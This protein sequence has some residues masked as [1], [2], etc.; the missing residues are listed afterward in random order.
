M[1]LYSTYVHTHANM[2][3]FQDARHC[4]ITSNLTAENCDDIESP[5]SR[6]I[7]TT[8]SLSISGRT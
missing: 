3:A 4:V 5:N 7:R 8:V 2:Q 6:E 1:L